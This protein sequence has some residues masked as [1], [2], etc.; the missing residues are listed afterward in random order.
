MSENYKDSDEVVGD[1]KGELV[2]QDTILAK[3]RV[4]EALSIKLTA[5][6]VVSKNLG[7]MEMKDINW[8]D[9]RIYVLPLIGNY[10]YPQFAEEI[11]HNVYD[12]DLHTETDDTPEWLS[13]YTLPDEQEI[14]DEI[15]ELRNELETKLSQLKGVQKYKE[16]LYET[17]T[18]LEETVHKT[19]RDMGFD[20]EDE[21]S[22]RRDGSVQLSDERM[23]LEIHGT[24]S[25]VSLN[26]CRQLD[27]WVERA[28]ADGENDANGLLV[29]NPMRK[30]DPSERRDAIPDNVIDYMEGRGYKILTTTEL[31]KLVKAEK[32][33]VLDKDAIEE[34][35]TE[36][37][38]VEID[39]V[40]LD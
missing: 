17:G 1:Q 8:W 36:P 27:D 33:N 11:L 16:L 10:K 13:E 28:I 6:E 35:L 40:E 31:L 20:V 19:F 38:I 39:E 3:N 4:D 34:R 26:K 21:K 30:K 2:F 5:G 37:T 29:V 24:T 32:E 23:I 9:G 15:S 7:N 14:L 25:G 18:T 22:G 12:F